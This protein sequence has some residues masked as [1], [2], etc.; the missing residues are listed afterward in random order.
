MSNANGSNLDNNTTEILKVNDVFK[1][2][3]AVKIAINTHAKHNGFIAIKAYKDVNV[4][5]KSII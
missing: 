3:D 2:W 1:D 5:D 4:I